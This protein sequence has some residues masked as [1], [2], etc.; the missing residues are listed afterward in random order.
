MVTKCSNCQIIKDDSLFRLRKR[1]YK[2][3]IIEYL[4]S[5][6]KSCEKNRNIEYKEKNRD[7]ILLKN[8]VK[9]Y[10]N[11][12]EISRKRKEKRD[13]FR[14][15]NPLPLKNKQSKEE[16]MAKIKEWQE[17]NP[18]KHKAT[19]SKYHTTHKEQ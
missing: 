3:S 10:T 9:Y 14:L 16:R 4:N 15:A 5:E 12:E 8:K 13:E 17:N 19:I 18:D 11:K 1:I 2:N 7:N 6:C